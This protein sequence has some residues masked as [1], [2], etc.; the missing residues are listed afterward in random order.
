MS[1]SV[2]GVTDDYWF[3]HVGCGDRFCAFRYQGVREGVFGLDKVL[4]ES[5]VSRVFEFRNQYYQ[6]RNSLFGTH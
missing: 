4:L 1:D 5:S 6:K 2:D 3:L